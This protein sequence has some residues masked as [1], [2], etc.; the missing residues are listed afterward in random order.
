[1]AFAF[2]GRFAGFPLRRTLGASALAVL[3]AGYFGA[4]PS[5]Q[6]DVTPPTVTV[7]S[8]A[9]NATGVSTLIV[10][11]ATFSEPVQS[12]T[13]V[14][15]LRN[16]SNQL[17]AA[18]VTYDAASR[19][20]SLDP[21]PELAGS[22]TFTVTV[23]GARDSAGNAMTAV[24]WP[25]TTGTAGFQDTVLPQTGLV[26]PAVIQ[27]AVDGRLFVAEKS[28]A[29]CHVYDSLSDTTP[30]LAV[31]LR[32]AVHNFWDRG[33]LGMV[34]HPNFPAT[35]VYLCAVRLRRVSRRHGT[36]VGHSRTGRRPLPDAAG[37]DRQ[38]LR[39]HRPD[40]AIEYRQ[41]PR[42]A[43]LPGERGSA[44]HRLVPTVPEPLDRGAGV[45]RGWR[46]LCDGR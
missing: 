12:G 2:A 7:R 36:A 46:A 5:G 32:T 41:Q 31:D 30:T 1:M 42:V 25:F 38:W 18:L 45:W 37:P 43:S 19:T 13:I 29:D 44:R 22:Q 27:F 15:Q 39:R 17:I 35:P 4:A 40:F 34:L 20:A 26:D 16:S 21:T 3:L 6:A 11:G 8:P 9:T 28:G 10:V 24:S 23:S 14:M 33:L